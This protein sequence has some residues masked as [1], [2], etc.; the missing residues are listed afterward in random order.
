MIALTQVNWGRFIAWGMVALS[1]TAACG[2][3]FVKD[4]RRAFYWFFAACINTTVTL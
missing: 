2:Y 1:L 3:L 4:Y